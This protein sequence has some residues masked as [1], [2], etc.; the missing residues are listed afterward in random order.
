MNKMIDERIKKSRRLN[1]DQ[2]CVFCGHES[3]N[4][5]EYVTHVCAVCLL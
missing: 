1:P 5:E 2:E 4:L 3:E